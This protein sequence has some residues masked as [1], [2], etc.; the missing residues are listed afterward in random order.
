MDRSS[1]SSVSGSDIDGSSILP[2]K[3]P[4]G[5]E[6]RD[7]DGDADDNLLKNNSLL[8][9]AIHENSRLSPAFH[10]DLRPSSKA[11]VI[12]NTVFFWNLCLQLKQ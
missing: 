5:E 11:F 12:P 1:Y 6:C 2:E 3:L 4:L 10:D 9:P 7:D 8:S